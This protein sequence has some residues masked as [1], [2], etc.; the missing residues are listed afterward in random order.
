[1]HL[2]FTDFVL[3]MNFCKIKLSRAS[4]K[5]KCELCYHMLL[6][7]LVSTRV[8]NLAGRTFLYGPLKFK[9]GSVAKLFCDLLPSVLNFYSK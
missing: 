8:V 9:V 4:H 2:E 1:M 3:I 6:Y 5:L 7:L